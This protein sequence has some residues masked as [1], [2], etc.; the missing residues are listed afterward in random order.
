LSST[1]DIRPT[2]PEYVAP[3]ASPADSA[4]YFTCKRAVDLFLASCLLLLL[5]PGLLLIGLLIRLE[6]PGPA[7]F[8]QRRVGSRRHRERGATIWKIRT[9]RCY[10]FRSM[11]ADAD[12]SLHRDYIEAFAAGRAGNASAAA[13]FKLTRDPRVTGVGQILRNTSLDELP[14]L[15]NVLKGDMS[16]VGP[17]PVPEYEAAAYAPAHFERLAA[18]PGITGLW[19]VRARS[20]VPFEEMIRLDV[21]YVRSRSLWLDLKILLLTFPAV[22][23]GRGAA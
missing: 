9:F 11:I 3:G 17:R 8:T 6:S 19:Q 23:M 13:R 16:L 12:Q 5:L 21:A 14:Q 18:L 2:W 4:A 15:I 10:K 7:I 22:V 1:C 20:Q